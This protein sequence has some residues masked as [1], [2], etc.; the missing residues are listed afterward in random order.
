MKDLESLKEAVRRF[1]SVGIDVVLIGGLAMIA[2]GANTLTVDVDF[3]YSVDSVN[4][5]RLAAFLPTI[6]ARVLGRP[7]NDNFVITT[8]TLQRVRFLNLY[9]DLGEVDIM[10]DIPGVESF[11]GLSQR[12]VPTDFGGFIV[13]IASLDDLIA[14]KRAANRPK[15]QG[16]LYELLA[17]KK[18]IGEQETP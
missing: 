13:R 17:L 1:H 15:D 14:M 6:H 18:L 5:E 8:G 3:A 2:H 11:E 9:T 10:R 7:A 12:S 4:L 16:H